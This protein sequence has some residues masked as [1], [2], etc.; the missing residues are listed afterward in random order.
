MFFLQIYAKNKRLK[1]I[2]LFPNYYVKIHPKNGWLVYNNSYCAPYDIPQFDTNMRIKK[3][4]LMMKLSKY[5]LY[6]IICLNPIP[7]LFHFVTSKCLEIFFK[8]SHFF[9]ILIMIQTNQVHDMFICMHLILTPSQLQTK[10]EVFEEFKQWNNF[11]T[12]ITYIS[13]WNCSIF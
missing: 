12:I 1:K 2:N 11:K 6:L 10:D 3:G 9:E 4:T 5:L 13:K 7:I 8:N